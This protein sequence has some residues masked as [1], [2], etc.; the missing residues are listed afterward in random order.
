MDAN[1]RGFFIAGYFMLRLTRLLIHA[2]MGGAWLS[3]SLGHGTSP[4]DFPLMYSQ[5]FDYSIV[6]LILIIFLS[7]D[8]AN[9]NIEKN[10]CFREIFFHFVIV[11]TLMRIAFCHDAERW[12]ARHSVWLQNRFT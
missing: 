6:A 7:S 5:P 2:C 8:I 11:V 10:Q 1:F 4:A 3:V 12:A 9:S